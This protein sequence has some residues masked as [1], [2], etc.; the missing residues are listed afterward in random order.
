[1]D[2]HSKKIHAVERTLEIVEIVS[3]IEPAGVSEIANEVPVSK[4]TVYTHLNTLT[5]NGYV[6]KD[7][8]TYQLGC[9]FLTLGSSVQ[10]RFDLYQMAKQHV[11]ELANK[12][13]E[14]TNLVVE[15]DGKGIC[16]YATNPRNSADVFMSSGE[17]NY[18]HATGT[19]KA[20]LAH[21]P[22]PAIEAVLDKHGLPELTEHTIT[23]REA[24]F[25]ELKQIKNRG[26]AFDR[27]E[28]IHGLYCISAPV[29]VDDNVLGAI[30]V[31]GP[32]NRFTNE[33]RRAELSEAVEEIAN[34]VELR[35][36]F[37]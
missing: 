26:L 18:M 31:S 32:V 11:D 3:E 16:L 23:S 9:K 20:I 27:Q 37:S 21:L 28:T 10:E 36:V 14:P 2:E 17:R 22:D 35:F 19:G 33:E 7:G 8:D 25:D 12:T 5:E 15:M 4:S 30:S 29:I 13:G 34:V 24:L 6:T 1:M